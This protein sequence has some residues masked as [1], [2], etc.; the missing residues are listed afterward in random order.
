MKKTGLLEPS[1]GAPGDGQDVFHIIATANGGPDHTDNYLFT[2]G[3]SFNRSISN[4]YDTFNLFIAGKKKAQNAVKIALEVAND[5]RLHKYIDKR[6]GSTQR[7]IFTQ[8]SDYKDYY[9]KHPNSE[10]DLADAMYH[11]GAKFMYA[12]RRVARTPDA[13][14]THMFDD[15]KRVA[16]DFGAINLSNDQILQILG[17]EDAGDES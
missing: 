13:L 14:Y 17:R 2:L 1:P 11:D 8:T 4:N 5:E 6:P 12:M 10:N 3:A 15:I 16:E 7:T 9:K